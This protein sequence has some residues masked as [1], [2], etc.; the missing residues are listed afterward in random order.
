[1]VESPKYRFCVRCP[2][3][4][5][6]PAKQNNLLNTHTD[7]PC[8]VRSFPPNHPATIDNVLRDESPGSPI[9]ALQQSKHRECR[10]SQ[11]L[12]P[13]AD[14]ATGYGAASPQAAA[15]GPLRPARS[16]DNREDRTCTQAECCPDIQEGPPCRAKRGNIVAGS[17]AGWGDGIVGLYAFCEEVGRHH[18]V[19]LSSTGRSLNFPSL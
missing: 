11:C 19:D 6:F 12:R 18:W 4:Q 10:R 17:A 16:V 5:P 14:I 1:M 8:V 9:P 15:H 13:E 2:N 3:N 7:L